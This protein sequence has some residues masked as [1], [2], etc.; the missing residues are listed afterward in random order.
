MSCRNT[1]VIIKS[2]VNKGIKIFSSKHM[3]V[4]FKSDLSLSV[5][6]KR[7]KGF[8]PGCSLNCAKWCMLNATWIVTRHINNS[9]LRGGKKRSVKHIRSHY[10]NRPPLILSCEVWSIHRSGNHK[11]EKERH[12]LHCGT[13]TQHV[14]KLILPTVFSRRLGHGNGQ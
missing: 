9:I 1:S 14:I 3:V 5:S 10:H 8:G 2:H 13:F 4:I 12:L 11:K 6:L 7:K